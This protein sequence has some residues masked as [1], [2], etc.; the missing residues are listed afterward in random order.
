MPQFTQFPLSINIG[1][2]VIAAVVI[3]IAG[4]RLSDVADR[5]ADKTGM[6]EAIA[7]AILLG[8]TTSLAGIITS[9]TAAAQGYPELS[10]SNAIGGIAAQTAFLAI[11]DLVYTRANLEHV[12]ASISNILQGTLLVILLMIPMLAAMSPHISFFAVHPATPIMFVVYIY[13]MRIAAKV[14]DNPMWKPHD[15]PETQQDE[16][17]EELQK[18]GL[19]PLVVR[20]GGFGLL[21]G[22]FGWVLANAGVAL[23]QQ[24]G[25]SETAVGGIFTA[26]STSLPELITSI[27]AV[28]QGAQMLAVANIIGGNA[29][30]TLF[31]AVA[32]IAYRDGSIYHA[33]GE[34]QM[35]IISLSVVMTAVLLMG[36]V[37]REKRG[38]ANIGFESVSILVLYVSALIFMFRT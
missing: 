6:G 5:L 7:G 34:Q 9:V 21:V 32:D 1:L 35:F 11:A 13:G 38:I 24:T 2:F 17:E 12:A 26:V 10:I 36:L 19:M 22:A 37:R 25:L 15:T 31:A 28:R 27:A 14:R 16:P 29:F 20:F 30:D 4:W 3:G 8:A 33:M 18:D 23:S